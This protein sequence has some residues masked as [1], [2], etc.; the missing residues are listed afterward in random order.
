MED[1]ILPRT[2]LQSTSFSYLSSVSRSATRR[3]QA[4]DPDRL[5]NGRKRNDVKK[6]IGQ[7]KASDDSV[8]GA[9]P[10]EDEYLVEWMGY[11]DTLHTV[12]V[13]GE[14]LQRS[15]Y[16]WGL[17]ENFK[18]AKVLVN[19]FESA[20]RL[21]ARYRGVIARRSTR[22]MMTEKKEAAQL[23][24]AQERQK[25]AKWNADREKRVESQGR[26]I[27]ASMYDYIQAAKIKV[28]DVFHKIDTS[29]DGHLDQAEFQAALIEMGFEL[30]I[31]A[32]VPTR[33]LFCCGR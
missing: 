30:P 14:W 23:L 9:L 1:G 29:G 2:S 8:S 20:A 21:Q 24:R 13:P 3:L 11:S 18:E 33:V 31:D 4:L 19:A 16:S 32:E 22:K 17:V 27:V 6:V 7:R 15:G 25:V 10:G 5:I 28:V 26:D 12:W